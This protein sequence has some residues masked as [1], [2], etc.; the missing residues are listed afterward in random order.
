VV[1]I[2]NKVSMVRERIS[3]KSRTPVVASSWIYFRC[4]RVC[5]R[6]EEVV[7]QEHVVFRPPPCFRLSAFSP[8]RPLPNHLARLFL[9]LLRSRRMHELYATGLGA[10]TSVKM[11]ATLLH[12]VGLRTRVKKLVNSIV[13]LYTEPISGPRSDYTNRQWKCSS[14]T[15]KFSNVRH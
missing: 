5:T 3:L 12:A 9:C 1:Y 14:K 13:R 4:A 6:V 8:A 2:E 11:M 10:P 15:A 7:A